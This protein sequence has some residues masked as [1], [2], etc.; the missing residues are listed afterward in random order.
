VPP[1]RDG[2]DD[3][4]DLGGCAARVR[5]FASGAAPHVEYAAEAE[6][7][8]GPS[9]RGAPQSGDEARIATDAGAAGGAH[10]A[11]YDVVLDLDVR[12]GCGGRIWPSARVL[13]QF[14]AGPA[15]PIRAGEGSAW[16][17]G[18]HVIELGSGTGLLGFLAA[19]LAPEATVY[20]TDQE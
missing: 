8:A 2:G 13:G 18:K 6:A 9:R 7:F 10:G 5:Y 14:L 11:H 1:P 12:N 20:V 3:P 4:N 16:G 17:R 15:S 19:K